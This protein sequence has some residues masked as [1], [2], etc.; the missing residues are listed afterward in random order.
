MGL[1]QLL[2]GLGALFQ[3]RVFSICRLV[4]LRF[5]VA[6]GFCCVFLG[7]SSLFG[8]QSKHVLE[9]PMILPRNLF[10]LLS[11]ALRCGSGIT[12]P[13]PDSLDFAPQCFSTSALGTSNPLWFEVHL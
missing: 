1:R 11:L 7:V 13:V 6:S 3:G 4:F 2:S 10:P 12:T 8:T 5:H 9:E